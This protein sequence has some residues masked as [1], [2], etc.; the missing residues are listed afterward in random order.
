MSGSHCFEQ[1]EYL[2]AV[3]DAL[4]RVY[5]CHVS[6][7]APVSVKE[8]LA[9]PS[10]VYGSDLV[11]EVVNIG[12]TGIESKTTS[13]RKRMSCISSTVSGSQSKGPRVAMEE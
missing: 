2:L 13:G 3:L 8:L 4:L 11:C 6:S 1:G 12:E 10:V 7:I 9:A 5:F